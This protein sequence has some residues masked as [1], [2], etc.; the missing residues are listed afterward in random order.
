METS[1]RTDRRDK[2][3]L[4]ARHG[5]PEVWLVDLPRRWVEIYREPMDAEYTERRTLSGGE[6]FSPAAFPD[7][8][9]TADAIVGPTDDETTGGA[10]SEK[11]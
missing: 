3:P 9:F 5:V 10:Q 7:A 4:Y 1:G 2:L 8:A 6:E 11:H